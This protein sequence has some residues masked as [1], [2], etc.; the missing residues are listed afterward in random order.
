MRNNIRYEHH[1][2]VHLIGVDLDRVF[3]LDECPVNTFENAF[4]HDFLVRLQRLYQVLQMPLRK[5]DLPRFLVNMVIMTRIQ[6]QHTNNIVACSFLHIDLPCRV[7]LSRQQLYTSIKATVHLIHQLVATRG[8]LRAL[9]SVGQLLIDC[10]IDLN[11]QLQEKFL[12]LHQHLID[13]LERAWDNLLRLDRL[14]CEYLQQVLYY[15]DCEL[16]KIAI[17]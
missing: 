16:I 17:V 2:L 9:N 12:L 15:L 8:R 13:Q 10:L 11:Q 4:L 5:V 14:K 1:Q 3:R 6:T 7:L